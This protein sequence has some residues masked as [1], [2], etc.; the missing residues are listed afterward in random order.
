V[1]QRGLVERARDGDHE[2]FTALIDL[3]IARLDAAARLIL[4]DPELARDAVQ[5]ALIRAWRDVPGLRDPDRFDAWINRLTVNACLDLARRRR[6][7][8]IEVE[9]TDLDQ[10]AARDM[11]M[12]VANRQ[13][14]DDALG[15]LDPERRALVVLHYFLGM[16]MPEIARAVGIPLGTAKSRMHHAIAAMREGLTDEAVATV[17]AV[18]RGQSA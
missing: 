11:S 1:D 8:P 13:L 9:I 4:R 15:R 17:A 3:T 10:P 6:R 18:A 2:A 14:L 12:D 7:R 16:P 5:E